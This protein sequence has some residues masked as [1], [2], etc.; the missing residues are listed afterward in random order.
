M[1]NVIVMHYFPKSGVLQALHG[2]ALQYYAYLC[3]YIFKI[4]IN[5]MNEIVFD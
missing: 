1:L 4:V 2:I 5:F 3:M